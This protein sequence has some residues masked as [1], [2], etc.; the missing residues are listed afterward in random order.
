MTIHTP[1]SSLKRN[2]NKAALGGGLPFFRNNTGSSGIASR[3]TAYNTFPWG[4]LNLIGTITVTVPTTTPVTVTNTGL[5]PGIL[6]AGQ[7]PSLLTV[8]GSNAHWERYLPQALFSDRC[9]RL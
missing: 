1:I 8:A 3:S 2:H 7:A 9:Q 5:Q 6:Q 4:L